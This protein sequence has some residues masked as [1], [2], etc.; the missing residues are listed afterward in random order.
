V[1][2]DLQKSNA[3]A[4]RR[5]TEALRGAMSATIS[6][7]GRTL[8]YFLPVRRTVVEPLTGE[9]EIKDPPASDGLVRR[10]IVEYPSSTLMQGTV[11]QVSPGKPNKVIVRGL[12]GKDP[13]KGSTQEQAEYRPFQVTTIGSLRAVT[14]TLVTQKEKMPS[15]ETRYVRMKTTVVL[16]NSGS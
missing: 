12:F 1:D 3:T 2:S 4:L 11:T 6:A 5:I 7:D 14:V 9:F 10:F 15:G 13:E 16:R 8:T